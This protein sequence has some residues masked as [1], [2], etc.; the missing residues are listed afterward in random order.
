MG[1]KCRG[2]HWEDI[3]TPREVR[4]GSNPVG[5]CQPIKVVLNKQD[6][7]KE[8]EEVIMERRKRT[9]LL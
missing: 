7:L 1:M 2:E 8:R 4:M 5:S 6:F 3:H 9:V